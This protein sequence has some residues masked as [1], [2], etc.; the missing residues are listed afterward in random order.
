M[1]MKMYMVI[2][3]IDGKEHAVFFDHM[4][5]ADNYCMDCQCGLGG[6]AQVYKWMPKSR[7]YKL[8]YE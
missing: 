3:R 8:Y 1:K 4:S 5:D 6:F 7:Q 2:T